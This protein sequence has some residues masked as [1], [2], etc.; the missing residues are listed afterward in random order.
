MDDIT[1]SHPDFDRS[2]LT[3]NQYI[4]QLLFEIQEL[5][6]M[7]QRKDLLIRNLQANLSSDKKKQ[8]QSVED[9]SETP[10]SISEDPEK[11][12][13]RD[14]EFITTPGLGVMG[15][16][17][18]NKE[19]TEGMNSPKVVEE[20]QIVP[21]RSAR[22]KMNEDKQDSI[23]QGLYEE[24]TPQEGTPQPSLDGRIEQD[25]TQKDF[26]ELVN[27]GEP[28][29]LGSNRSSVY[30]NERIVDESIDQDKTENAIDVNESI[31]TTI[32]DLE[33]EERKVKSSP[34]KSEAVFQ[35]KNAS[36]SSFQSYR[37]RIKLPSHFQSGP[38]PTKSQPI[39]ASIYESSQNQPSSSQVSHLLYQTNP[40]NDQDS[41]LNRQA[42]HHI[43]S[44]QM[45]KNNQSDI[46]HQ[47]EL[48]EL[49]DRKKVLNHSRTLR[50][51]NINNLTL[52]QLTM[53]S[54]TNLRSPAIISPN[55]PDGFY[56]RDNL[57][58]SSSLSS[59]ALNHGFDES[60]RNPTGYNN[61]SLSVNSFEVTNR[62]N[63]SLNKDEDG[64]LFIKPEDFQSINIY[65]ISTISLGNLQP[66]NVK[67][68]DEILITLSITD[69]NSRKE[70]WKIQKSY[71]QLQS[72][73]NEIRPIVEYFGLPELPD[74]SLFFSTTPN[75]ID[76]RKNGLQNYFNTLFV[77]PHI[78]HLILFRICKYLSLDMIN[79]L[80]NFKSGAKKEG[81]L[82]RRYKGLGT[83]WKIRWCQVDGPM[84][85]LYDSPGGN[86]VELINLI[87][88]QIGRQS[89]DSVAEDKGYRHAFL[90]METVKSS[91]LSNSLPK[92][93]F[94]AESDEERDDWVNIL[95]EN[96]EDQS[97][98]Q[99][100]QSYEDDRSYNGV[101]TPQTINTNKSSDRVDEDS[102]RSPI[103]DKKLN[104]KRSLFAFRKNVPVNQD[105][106]DPDNLSPI[107]LH[108]SHGNRSHDDIQMYLDKMGLD[109]GVSKSIFG[110]DLISVYNISNNVFLQRSIPS[111]IF[112]CIDFLIRTGAIYEEGIFRLSGSASTIRQLKE[113]FNRKFDVDL[114]DTKSDIHTVAGL[115]KT[116]LRELPEP[117]ITE[118]LLND[119]RQ[120]MMSRG[121]P[122]GSVS[123]MFRDHISKNLDK[124]HYDTTY[125]ILK[126]LKEIINNHKVNKM[127]LRNVCIVFVPTLNISLDVLSLLLVDFNCIFENQN[128]IPDDK[129]EVLVLNIP[130]F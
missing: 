127:N 8:K 75:K 36:I 72:F 86:L 102:I 33:P 117:I 78:P 25:D 52:G 59:P 17:D 65:V 103:D 48:K 70:M 74:K 7:L 9:V 116:Y 106:A 27:E 23:N 13:K 108:S 67:K 45:A 104:H 14:E 91:K 113:V 30:S 63:F 62:S 46:S 56:N 2:G 31:D 69:R 3:D 124:I 126:F 95:I 89:N 10:G 109:E 15:L 96:T 98:Q 12:I 87:S 18:R 43:A 90:I 84:L 4:E 73:D 85:E 81:Y 119:L 58:E 112:R 128:P 118:R 64:S 76:I 51:L 79:P 83:S 120:I 88:C 130:N 11:E 1:P 82:V 107:T 77:M 28:C 53:P 111:I 122:N 101:E 47:R 37:S 93:F 129:R 32:S 42:P 123:L 50:D 44:S 49:D 115:F 21:Q 94:C 99:Y 40:E 125:I 38:S 41:Q 6:S 57:G 66:S 20:L 29:E 97:S 22:R 121:T 16:Y 100:N 19:Q 34:L 105:T 61:S 35:N 24:G 71:S 39:N 80:D 60:K 114:L 92:H 5:K 110:R 55:N 68:L 54:N 26:M